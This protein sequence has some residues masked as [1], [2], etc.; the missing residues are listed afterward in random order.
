[1][2]KIFIS[3][4]RDD[5]KGVAGR[6]SDRLKAHFGENEVFFDVEANY[7]GKFLDRIKTEADS[8]EVMVVLIGQNW[9]TTRG[10][11]GRSRLFESD[12]FVRIECRIGL[13]KGAVIPTIVED[14]RL[15]EKN[16]LPEDIAQIVAYNAVEIRHTHFDDGVKKLIGIIAEKVSPNPAAAERKTSSG[17]TSVLGQVLSAFVEGQRQRA[18]EPAAPRQLDNIPTGNSATLPLARTIPG[19][20][21]L[22]ITY[23]SGM[24]GQATALFEPSGSFRAEGRSPVAMFTI[25][26]TWKADAADQLSLRGRQSDGAQTVPYYAVIGFSEVGAKGMVSTLNTG[27]RVVWHRMR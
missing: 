26:G 14:A 3:Y 1:M 24:I 11:D 15:P 25:D 9:L 18:T 21:Q 20:W 17:W 2:A 7:S 5:A 22:Q 6:V 27:E 19:L 16:Q 8:C 12:D 13:E 4:R 23:P 10:K